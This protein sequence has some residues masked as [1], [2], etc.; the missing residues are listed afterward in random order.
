MAATQACRSLLAREN[1]HL[2]LESFKKLL[3]VAVYELKQETGLEGELPEEASA[4]T[5]VQYVPHFQ[6]HV[7]RVILFV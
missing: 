1:E 6:L 4:W 2:A 5:L 7:N 3:S